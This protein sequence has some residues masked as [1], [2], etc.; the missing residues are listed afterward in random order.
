MNVNCKSPART[1]VMFVALALGWLTPALAQYDWVVQGHTISNNR[2]FPGY[3]NRSVSMAFDWDPSSR[4]QLTISLIIAQGRA[5]RSFRGASPA[6]A[7]MIVGLGGA[8]YT[9]RTMQADYSGDIEFIMLA[10]SQL[11]SA[12]DFSNLISVQIP[13]QTPAFS[14]PLAGM[15]PALTQAKSYCR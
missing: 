2:V 8:S 11:I 1:F 14:F 15:A 9:G 4:C 5:L 6:P 10:P 12:L 3:E 13:G 7:N